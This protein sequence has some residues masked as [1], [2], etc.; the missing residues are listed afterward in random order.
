[1]TTPHKIQT[2]IVTKDSSRTILQRS[3]LGA[4]LALGMGISLS[5]LAA[6]ATSPQAA[7][8]N[9]AASAQR[10]ASATSALEQ[11]PAQTH[12]DT[13]ATDDAPTEFA[14]LEPTDDTA[15]AA[16]LIEAGKVVQQPSQ[17]GY[18]IP[19]D[20]EA[21]GL[22]LSKAKE[23]DGKL[24]QV[25]DSGAKITFTVIPSVQEKLEKM[26]AQYKIP[27]GGLV[28]LEPETGRVLAMVSQTASNEKK[29]G[30]I[31]RKDIA[32]S[33]SV[34]K[35]VTIAALIEGEGFS[36]SKEVCYH[37]GIRSLTKA[38]IEG[39]PRRDTRCGD[40]SD[41]M[42]WSINSLIAKLAYAHLSKDELKGWAERFAYNQQIPFELDIAPST[43][44]TVSD[45]HEMARSAAGFWHSTLSPLH[46]AM[47]SAAV[48]NDGVM[49]QPS[50]IERFEDPSGKTLKEFE[51]KRFKRV[52]KKQTARTLKSMMERTTKV[53]TARKYF[54]FRK[55]FPKDINTGGKTGTLSRK[56]PSYL[57]YT[58]FVGFGED[59]KNKDIDVAV[60]GLVCNKPLWHIKG[61]YAAS[62]GIRLA[63][64][65]LR[66]Q[67]KNKGT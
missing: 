34:F 27:Y 24:V 56:S 62:E 57:G 23:V 38:N 9:A 32:P 66:T 60:G 52:M 35:V 17:E 43:F 26:Y 1:M 3:A 18:T 22:D 7:I 21:A 40:L 37:G 10:S 20:W 36:P 50:L 41:A 49:M 67:K 55:D 45:R 44:E 54:R 53:G 58:W 31:A 61:P 16:A 5:A 46:G 11:I 59:S 28:V 2:H 29:I 51:A 63:I 14:A 48:L 33:A 13:V 47:I 25:L 6:P 30:D 39:D 64:E 65:S 19:S 12:T 4:V 8:H 42:A 15:P